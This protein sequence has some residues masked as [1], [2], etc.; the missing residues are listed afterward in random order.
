MSGNVFAVGLMSSLLLQVGRMLLRRKIVRE[1][2][3]YIDI[4]G[5]YRK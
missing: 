5:G 1:G 2:I 3:I 4:A